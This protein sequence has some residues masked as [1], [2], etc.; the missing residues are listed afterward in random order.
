MTIK[1]YIHLSLHI[2]LHIATYII[3]F[4]KAL[5]LGSD[6]RPPLPAPQGGSKDRDRE[7]QRKGQNRSS[8]S[9][10]LNLSRGSISNAPK[11]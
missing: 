4:F 3:I 8:G 11:G 6:F 7:P 10:K 9:L 2:N 5:R 1:F